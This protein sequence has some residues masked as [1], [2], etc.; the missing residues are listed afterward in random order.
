M[1]VGTNLSYCAQ[2]VRQQDNDRFLCALFAPAERRE[3]LFALYAFNL[4][5]ASVPGKVSEPLLGR[6]RFQWWREA[7]EGALDGTPVHHQVMEP[8]VRA[9]DGTGLDKAALHGLIDARALD[10]EE[11]PIADWA[12]LAAYAADTAGALGEMSL[13]VLGV[14]HGAAREAARHVGQAVAALDI[15]R[16]LPHAAKQRLYLPQESMAAAGLRANAI[17]DGTAP[18]ALRRVVAE[19]VD[20]AARH[21]SAARLN[22]GDIPR[23]ALPALL[24]AALADLQMKR[25]RRRAFDPFDPS[26][27]R[28]APWRIVR[29]WLR[30]RQNRF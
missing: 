5:L 9:I 10:L 6:M 1:K 16:S 14:D 24:P 13:D 23:E 30:A 4:E 20:W 3:A 18:A 27:R 19:M 8:L 17:F 15:L 26:L 25:L 22:R 29:L 28:P 2:Q 7:L 21:L 11:A 12:A